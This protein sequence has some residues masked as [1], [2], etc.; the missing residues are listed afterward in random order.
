MI[1]EN[2]PK[3]YKPQIRY[4][5]YSYRMKIVY[6]S[7]V[8]YM[9]LYNI[10][11]VEKLYKSIID[12]QQNLINDKIV[13]IRITKRKNQEIIKEYFGVIPSI[14]HIKAITSQN[15]PY[16]FDKKTLSFFGQTMK[17]FHVVRSKDKTKV[18]IVSKLWSGK[19]GC[20]AGFTIRQLQGNKLLY[21]DKS[22]LIETKSIKEMKNCLRQL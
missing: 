19:Y 13:L 18:Y 21:V 15:S 4:K 16:F 22:K 2:F 20:F 10:K 9:D 14:Y 1:Q 5:S 8:K 3:M 11:Q 12:N 6:L 17:N 7:I